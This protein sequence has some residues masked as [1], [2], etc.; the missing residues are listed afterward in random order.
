MSKETEV[1]PK[2]P[3]FENLPPVNYDAVYENIHDWAQDRT[4]EDTAYSSAAKDPVIPFAPLTREIGVSPVEDVETREMTLTYQQQISNWVGL[5]KS[6]FDLIQRAQ[7]QETPEK[8]YHG[9]QNK[10]AKNQ[11]DPRSR[12]IT[13][14]SSG[15]KAIRR[16]YDTTLMHSRI[17][18]ERAQKATL[19]LTHLRDGQGFTAEDMHVAIEILQELAN[20]LAANLD[21]KFPGGDMEARIAGNSILGVAEG[22]ETGTINPDTQKRLLYAAIGYIKKQEKKWDNKLKR[23]YDFAAEKGFSVGQNSEEQIV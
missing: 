21:D 6:P 14:S 7:G 10:A 2:L 12:A 8:I 23:I 4:V 22:I 17:A 1:H 13:R 20:G 16:E 19:G 18:N 5:V 3:D 15:R 11:E 9:G